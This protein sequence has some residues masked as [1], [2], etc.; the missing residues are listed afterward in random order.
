MQT[1]FVACHDTL[2]LV[3]SC[4]GNDNDPKHLSSILFCRFWSMLKPGANL[5]M[6]PQHCTCGGNCQVAL[7]GAFSLWSI[8]ILCR[9]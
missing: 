8:V 1:D 6:L 9:K 4:R 5:V 3:H 7:H 2:V